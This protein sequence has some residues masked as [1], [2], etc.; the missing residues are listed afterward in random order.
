[1]KGKLR[2]FIFHQIM[3]ICKR[4][5]PVGEQRT[6]VSWI[7]RKYSS[8]SLNVCTEQEV[9]ILGRQISCLQI[10]AL[11]LF[12]V[13]ALLSSSSFSP[14]Q[15][16]QMFCFLN[17]DC[18]PILEKFCELMVHGYC[19]HS[20]HPETGHPA[21]STVQYKMPGL[22]Q[23]STAAMLFYVTHHTSALACIVYFSSGSGTLEK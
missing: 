5:K 7:T 9:F 6:L 19:I 21:P 1:M 10:S 20:P 3:C 15:E 12:P 16:Q 13:C 14:P 4:W 8:Q 2:G 22:E 23:S 17:G 11:S 18:R